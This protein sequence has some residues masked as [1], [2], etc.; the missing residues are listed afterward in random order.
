M[1]RPSGLLPTSRHALLAVVVAMTAMTLK[2]YRAQI[3][4][5][6]IKMVRRLF[7]I[8]SLILFFL[9]ALIATVWIDILYSLIILIPLFLIGVYDVVQPQYNILRLYPLI[10]HLRYM[11]QSIRPQIQQYF[12]ETNQSGK[13]FSREERELVYNRANKKLDTLPFGT[14]RD[15]HAPGFD[16]INHSLCPREVP[17]SEARII[18]GGPQCSKPYNASRLN[19]S[20]MSFGAISKNAVRALN[21]GAK[22]GNFAHNTGEGGLSLHHLRE[23]GDLTWQIGTGYFGCRTHDGKFDPK[24]FEQKSR[25]EQVKMIEIKL[26]QGAK[27][28]HG[29]ILPGVKVTAEIA[30]IRGVPMGEDVISPPAHSAFIN[31]KGLLEFVVQLRELSGGKP[32]GFKLCV[33]ARR[34]FL[35]ICKAMLATGIYPDFITVDGAEGG[36]GAAPVEFTDFIGVPLNE[37]LVFVHNA[38]V[39]IGVRDHIR[40]ICSAKIISGFDMV[41]K[42]ALGADMCNSARGMMFALGCVQ[43][44]RCHNNMCPTGVTTQ[45]PDRVYVL[46]IDNKAPRVR[47][48]HDATIKSFLTVLGAAGLDKISSLNASYIFHLVNTTDVKHYDEIYTFLKPN[49]LLDGPIP[50]SYKKPWEDA[51]AEYFSNI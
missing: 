1:A 2:F 15:V 40:I 47:N 4:L 13:P 51:N 28:A 17:E 14:Q 43:S 42:M 18:V 30:E 48:F 46:D 24:Q 25:S 22:M 7:W 37:G 12:I 10:G 8:I 34:E 35:G 3:I 31:P 45:K 41:C 6:L 44:R 33:G 5:E 36:T 11:L 19:I 9:V 23:G 29:G 38:L 49:Q 39:G 50:E 26:S 20:A 16:S 27:P 21:R 32:V